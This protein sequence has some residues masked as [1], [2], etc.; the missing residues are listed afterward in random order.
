MRGGD[1]SVSSE[2]TQG[3][4]VDDCESAQLVLE[5]KAAAVMLQGCKD[6][7]VS[8][9]GDICG[10]VELVG[11]RGCTVAVKASCSSLVLDKCTA[12]RL[13]FSAGHAPS[14]AKIFTAH[15]DATRIEAPC[16]NRGA[17]VASDPYRIEADNAPLMGERWRYLTRWVDDLGTHVTEQCDLYGQAKPVA[18]SR[19]STREPSPARDGNNSGGMERI[20][21]EEEAE[22]EIAD[23]EHMEEVD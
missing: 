8:L 7:N 22:E 10:A 5:G 12:T 23:A 17:D 4:F 18:A 15:C 3:I 1:A 21:E 13:V 20:G 6:C 14:D 9:C 16:D 11:C 2:G 19:C